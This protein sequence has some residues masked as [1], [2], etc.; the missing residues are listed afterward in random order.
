M[1]KIEEV[2]FETIKPYGDIARKEH[3]LIS[4]DFNYIACLLDDCIA[5]F[6]A[7]TIQGDKATFRNDFVLPEYRM[8]GIYR[9]MNDYRMLLMK[10]K[11]VKRVEVN[12]KPTSL[13]LHIRNGGKITRAFKYSTRVMY[14]NI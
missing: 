2:P 6:C 4:P 1:R 3:I 5:G 9:E 8:K 10:L 12:C 14:E 11:G 13:A 7:Y